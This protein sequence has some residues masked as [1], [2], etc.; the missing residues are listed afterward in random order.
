MDDII[1]MQICNSLKGLSKKTESLGLSEC[2]FG[3]LVIEEVS[4]LGIFH[5]HIDLTI[6]KDSIPQF[7]YVRVVDSRVNSYLPL[8]QL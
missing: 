8:E 5:D 4:I 7:Y 2:C 3:I 6:F 1:F